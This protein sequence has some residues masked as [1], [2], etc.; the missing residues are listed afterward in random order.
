MTNEE[1]IDIWKKLGWPMIDTDNTLIAGAM[2]NGVDL[3]ILGS[4]GGF[5][6]SLGYVY[7]DRTWAIKEAIQWNAAR[8]NILN[9]Y[10]LS[11]TLDVECPL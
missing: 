2:E 8:K 1:Q 10:K 9:V 5:G 4:F 7:P 3:Y 6:G 11:C